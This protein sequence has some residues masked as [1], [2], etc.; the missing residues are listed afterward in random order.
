MG[1]IKNTSDQVIINNEQE[2]ITPA[3][4]RQVNDV[5]DAQ[6]EA[7][8]G[9]I[10]TLQQNVQTLGSGVVP[11]GGETGQV[12]AK[13]SNTD[14]D[15]AWVNIPSSIP[16]GGT[17]GQVLAKNSDTDKDV[18]WVNAGGGDFLPLAGGTMQGAIN[19]GEYAIVN[20][21]AI[22]FKPTPETE[23][24]FSLEEL[25]FETHGEALT[26]SPS[27]PLPSI[28]ENPHLAHKKYVDDAITN[29]NANFL[30]LAGGTMT[31]DIDTNHKITST[32]VGEYGSTTIF[33]EPEPETDEFLVQGSIRF[34]G[35][36]KEITGMQEIVGTGNGQIQKFQQISYTD[37]TGDFMGGINLTNLQVKNTGMNKSLRYEAEPIIDDDLDISHKGYVDSSV[38]ISKCILANFPPANS[39]ITI[40]HGFEDKNVKVE[41]WV[42]F[43][44]GT[45]NVQSGYFNLPIEDSKIKVV[46]TNP[47]QIKIDVL[48]NYAAEQTYS[49]IEILVY[50][51]KNAVTNDIVPTVTP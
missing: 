23:R 41:I 28:S 37:E 30:P 9:S 13:N 48:G 11:T 46:R 1:A 36:E 33:I 35:E 17:T 40:N 19:M 22:R 34:V 29:A 16:N 18:A 15:T 21:P 12:L 27:S 47:N 26:Y 7:A 5:I 42:N 25:T 44:N 31:G 45:L 3:I 38:R 51:Y 39:V 2:L 43:Q 24:Y 20:I 14:R 8:K 49:D 6:V 10:N 50:S 32:H 4:V